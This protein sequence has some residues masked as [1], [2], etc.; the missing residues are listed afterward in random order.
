MLKDIRYYQ[1][2]VQNIWISAWIPSV[3]LIKDE[4]AIGTLAVIMPNIGG[5]KEFKWKLLGSVLNYMIMFATPVWCKVIQKQ[6][7]TG[8]LTR[9][10]RLKIYELSSPTEQFAGR[11]NC[12]DATNSATHIGPGKYAS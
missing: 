2:L 12:S 7:M 4:I 3:R 8:K 11:S 5:S 9:V 1:V 10:Q 6:S